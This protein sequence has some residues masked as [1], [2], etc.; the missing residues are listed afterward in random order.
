MDQS[1]LTLM[2]ILACIV[3]PKMLR[4]RAWAWT[5]PCWQE[6]WAQ[7]WTPCLEVLLCVQTLYCPLTEVLRSWIKNSSYSCGRNRS[8]LSGWPFILWY[9]SLV[10][11]YYELTQVSSCNKGMSQAGSLGNSPQHILWPDHHGKDLAGWVDFGNC[12]HHGCAL[13]ICRLFHLVW[14]PAW[15][16]AGSSQPW[17]LRDACGHKEVNL[18]IETCTRLW[19]A[20]SCFL[21][22][23]SL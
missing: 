19:T 13:D 18:Y 12:A 4:L 17:H 9:I 14:I 22:L 20:L 1:D 15:I 3:S 2:Q 23:F 6:L 11:S 5:V 16:P 21:L 7:N 8:F 10:F